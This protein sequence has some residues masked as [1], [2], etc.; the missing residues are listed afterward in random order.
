MYRHTK[1]GP[2]QMWSGGTDFGCQKWSNSQE[3]L[4][5]TMQNIVAMP[6]KI[7]N[8]TFFY[9]HGSYIQCSNSTANYYDLIAPTKRF[10]LAHSEL[11]VGSY[12]S[13]PWRGGDT[14]GASCLYNTQ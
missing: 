2:T 9:V 6:D 8:L 4:P 3:S 5:C 14:G 13:Q 1:I 12:G 11:K 10:T 7:W